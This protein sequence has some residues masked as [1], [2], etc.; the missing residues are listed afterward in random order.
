[1]ELGAAGLGVKRSTG[2]SVLEVALLPMGWTAALGD[3][4]VLLKL[5]ADDRLKEPE[6]PS[7]RLGV[8]ALL[9]MEVGASPVAAFAGPPVRDDALDEEA[10][11]ETESMLLAAAPRLVSPLVD[12]RALLEP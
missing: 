5:G 12:P 3:D 7:A 11:A 6:L 8:E 10:G 2:A 1:M 4:G 9:P